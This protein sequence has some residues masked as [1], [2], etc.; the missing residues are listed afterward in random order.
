MS[1]ASNNTDRE[2]WRERPGEFYG[3]S[4]HV[5]KDKAIGINKGGLVIVATAERWH[6]CGKTLLT[7][8]PDLPQWRYRLGTWLLKWKPLDPPKHEE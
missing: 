8:D 7:V 4:M 6:V 5:T 1:L 2:I 3:T